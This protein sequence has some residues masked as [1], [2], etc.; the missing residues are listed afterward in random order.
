[1]FLTSA[2]PQV[3]GAVLDIEKPRIGVEVL[4]FDGEQAFRQVEHAVERALGQRLRCELAAS[5]PRSI[6]IEVL[7]FIGNPSGCLLGE[8]G[9]PKK[10]VRAPLF[11]IE[12]Q[13]AAAG[14]MNNLVPEFARE[15]LSVVG[16]GL[17]QAR[18]LGRELILGFLGRFHRLDPGRELQEWQT[19]GMLPAGLKAAA[20][21]RIDLM[22]IE[23][24][25][26]SYPR[27]LSSI[28]ATFK[29]S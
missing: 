10:N 3:D 20:D 9:Y 24:N 18:Q 29:M 8:L 12:H 22:S 26:T 11:A 6:L 17:A 14:G 25:L 16:I 15:P 2:G 5:G 23:A 1:M 4:V 27:Q 28:S 7:R 19:S 21:R 13:P